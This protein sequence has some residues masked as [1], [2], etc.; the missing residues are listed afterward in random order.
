MVCV[1]ARIETK[2]INSNAPSAPI[3]ANAPPAYNESVVSEGVVATVLTSVEVGGW[4]SN[5]VSNWL[6]TE[7]NKVY[8]NETNAS[9]LVASILAKFDGFNGA[10]LLGIKND[11]SSLKSMFDNELANYDTVKAILAKIQ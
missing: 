1:F 10:A 2:L 9:T 6:Q 7:L 4:S 3:D 8:A 5:Q 11:D